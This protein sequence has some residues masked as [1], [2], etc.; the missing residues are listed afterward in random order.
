MNA[1]GTEPLGDLPL[2][3]IRDAALE[4]ARR[5][6]CEHADVRI[7]AIRTQRMVL[8]DA[9]VETDADESVRGLGVR[10]VRNGS[11]GF[12]GTIELTAAGA[13]GA[14]GVA[15]ELARASSAAG[16]RPV[17]LAPEPS[18]G[19]VSWTSPH[20]IDPTSVPSHEKA[21]LL[22]SWSGA[23]LA[24]PSVEHV[25]ASVE[26]VR[27][28]KH[29][30]DVSGTVT[31]QRRVRVHPVVEVFGRDRSGEGDSVRT[32]APPVGR[33]WEY[34]LGEGFDHAGE[35]AELGELLAEKLAA[36]T[37]EPG[38]Y[39]LVIDP[40]N[41]WL[42]IHESVGHALELDRAL[43]FEAAYAGTSFATPDGLGRLRYGSPAMTV[44]GDR[45]VPYGLATVAYDDEGVAAQSFPLV[46]EGVLVGYQLDRAT[47]AAAGLTRSNG[48]AYACSPLHIPIQRMANVSLAPAP[49]E[50]PTT[51][52]LLAALGDGLYVVGDRS[53][54]I[55]MERHNFQFSAQRFVRIRH[56]HP[57]GQVRFAAYQG[58][59]TD[60]WGR[61]EA[62]GGRGT[63]V[64]GGALNCGKGQPGQSAPVSHGCPAALFRRVNVLSSR[65]EAGR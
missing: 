53:W 57:A 38:E 19:V 1:L 48:C 54:S 10:V 24:Q 13:V 41:L 3:E 5:L 27:E 42:T 63:Y 52:E 40:S 51:A 55:D 18:H 58:S 31:T 9:V 28:V 12:A 22:E 59:T 64:L 2:E 46:T 14:V 29:Y 17:A 34:L 6:G 45:T 44:T 4:T 7:E 61:L 11:I 32:L 43:G 15:V 65:S 47:A 37:V 49:S 62:V 8:R 35:Q 60:F 23:L 39:D 50:G 26:A 21:A 33:G 25:L 36:P 56:G 30:A 16:G 20:E